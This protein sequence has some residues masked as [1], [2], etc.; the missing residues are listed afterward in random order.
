MAAEGNPPD[1]DAGLQQVARPGPPDFLFDETREVGTE[2]GKVFPSLS[3]KSL[4]K[5]VV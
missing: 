1:N 4:L 3:T 2:W 5:K